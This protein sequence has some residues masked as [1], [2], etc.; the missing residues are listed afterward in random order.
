MSFITSGKLRDPQMARDMRIS[1]I[2]SLLTEQTTRLCGTLFG[3][4]ADAAFWTLTSSG[5]TAAIGSGIC[6]LSNSTANTNYGNVASVRKGRFLFANPNMWRGIVR[7]PL[8]AN[9]NNTRRFGAYVCTSAPAPTDGFFFEVAAS[10]ALSVNYA[11]AGSVVS[12]ASTSFNGDVSAYTVDTNA[13]AYEIIYFV[14][15]VW[16]LV[17]GVLLHKFTPTTA[18]FSSTY[19]YQC[20]AATV[21]IGTAVASNL[22]IWSMSILRMGKEVTRPQFLNL[23]ANA[24]TTA[25]NSPGTLQKIIVGNAGT[26]GNTLNIYDNTAA[27]GTV[28]FTCATAA[29]STAASLDLNIDFFTGLTAIMATGGAANIT[30]VFD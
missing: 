2:G 27:S 13:H 5:G 29:M 21:N 12:V 7:I 11:N 20:Q 15:S 28:I 19:H 22:E 18:P 26:G 23:T 30:L 24:T 10:G 4:S 25:K 17:D 6:T 14:A 9:A 1:P 3:A 16:F 8:V